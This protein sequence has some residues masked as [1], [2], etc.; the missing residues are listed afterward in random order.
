MQGSDMMKSLPRREGATMRATAKATWVLVPLL[1]AACSSGS[2]GAGSSGSGT[3]A[4]GPAQH[5]SSLVGVVGKN[6][7][8]TIALTDPNGTPI[9]HLAA[10][11]YQLTVHDDSG[12][13]D[14]HLF[15]AGVS[16]ST[17]VGG[18][19]TQTFTVTFKPGTYTF[20]CDP[21]KSSMHGSFT[22]S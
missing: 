16:D 18:T 7:A 11:T 9:S 10:G 21:H 12:I 17:T 15:G 2:S 5:P 19:G 13:H 22:V 14:F 8:F 1:A 20:Q 3:P 6:D 4:T